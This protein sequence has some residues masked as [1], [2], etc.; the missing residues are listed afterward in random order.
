MF[1]WNFELRACSTIRPRD[2]DPPACGQCALALTGDRENTRLKIFAAKSETSFHAEEAACN[3]MVEP[4]SRHR[5]TA[6]CKP[7]KVPLTQLARTKNAQ[8]YLQE[9]FDRHKCKEQDATK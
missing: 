9:Q 4:N 1:V 8:D 5:R 2:F 7:F 3:P 6:C